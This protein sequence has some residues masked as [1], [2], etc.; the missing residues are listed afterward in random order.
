MATKTVSWINSES[1]SNVFFEIVRGNNTLYSISKGLDVYPNSVQQHLN[2]FLKEKIITKAKKEGKRGK[3]EYQINWAILASTCLDQDISSLRDS[4]SKTPPI[5]E[6]KAFFD[7]RPQI[8]KELL[9]VRVNPKFAEFVKWFFTVMVK[10]HYH[11]EYRTVR[12]VF[13]MLFDRQ[14]NR[15]F[16]ENPKY[17]FLLPLRTVK[18]VNDHHEQV[19]RFIDLN[20]KP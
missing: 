5:K 19:F 6:S 2:F 20:F 1:R 9:K 15:F 3:V 16:T 17:A 4:I 18:S 14:F 8:L 12:R 10:Q 13:D 11:L 7:P